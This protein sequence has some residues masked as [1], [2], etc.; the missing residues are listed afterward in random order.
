MVEAQ[1]LCSKLQEEL[2]LYCLDAKQDRTYLQKKYK[3]SE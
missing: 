1:S 2:K 3:K